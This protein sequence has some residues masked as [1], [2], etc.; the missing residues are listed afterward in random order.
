MFPTYR[1]SYRFVRNA[2]PLYGNIFFLY[3]PCM[4]EMS[5]AASMIDIVREELSK[6]GATKLH[7][8][9]VGHGVLSNLVPESM[10]FAF[11]VQTKGTDLDGAILELREIPITVACGEC[12]K[13]FQ[14]EGKDLF[15]MPCPDC[16]RRYAHKV[17]TG[18]ELLVEHIEAE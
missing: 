3:G 14:P 17:L 4:H 10:H 7:M 9:R 15:D 18:K 8:I 12:G 11:E 5:I 1:L 2:S 16:G 13:E 6:H